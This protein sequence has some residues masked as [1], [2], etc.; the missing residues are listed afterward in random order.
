MRGE[1]HVGYRLLVVRM[2]IVTLW[3]DL[4]VLMSSLACDLVFDCRIRHGMFDVG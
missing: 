3:S 1:R 2:E 4:A